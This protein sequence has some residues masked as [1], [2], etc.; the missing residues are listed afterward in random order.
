MLG[1]HEFYSS[2]QDFHLITLSE[3]RCADGFSA[4][5]LYLVDTGCSLRTDVLQ[6]TKTLCEATLSKQ[7][8]MIGLTRPRSMTLNRVRQTSAVS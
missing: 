6:T 7:V 2:D 5:T 1:Q 3:N 8:R 4:L